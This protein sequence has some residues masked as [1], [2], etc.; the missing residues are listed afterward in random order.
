[1]GNQ[2]AVLRQGQAAEEEHSECHYQIDTSGWQD[3]AC[4]TDN[5]AVEQNAN[6]LHTT[7]KV[8]AERE[9]QQFKNEIPKGQCMDVTH[10]STTT[11]AHGVEKIRSQPYPQAQ[12][13]LGR[14]WKTPEHTQDEHQEPEAE[15]GDAPGGVIAKLLLHLRTDFV[16]FGK[17]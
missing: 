12:E 3:E 14:Y 11:E 4:I 10:G 8:N 15:E 1:M 6:P 16:A 17:H 9:H 5:E 2:T 13:N 7:K